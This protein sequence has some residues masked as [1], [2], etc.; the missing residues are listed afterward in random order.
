MIYYKEDKRRYYSVPNIINPL[1]C[2]TIEIIFKEK[3]RYQRREPKIY[4][5]LLPNS[6]K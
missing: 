1:V 5:I 6:T 2:A 4:L 3:E